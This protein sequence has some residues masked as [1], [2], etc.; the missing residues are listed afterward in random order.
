MGLHQLPAGRGGG[1]GHGHGGRGPGSQGPRQRVQVVP[2]LA[3]SLTPRSCGRCRL[4]S[5]HLL[6]S[7]RCAQK[8]R[9]PV[10]DVPGASL[11]GPCSPGQRCDI[12]RRAPRPDPT[13]HAARPSPD[14]FPVPWTL[15]LTFPGSCPRFRPAPNTACQPGW[16]L[17]GMSEKSWGRLW[18]GRTDGHSGLQHR[19]GGEAGRGAL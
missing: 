6:R 19:A 8:G 2:P 13:V 15:H 4:E 14:V 7:A 3:L 17:V 1:G 16:L 12:S 11:A 5:G 18:D 10:E 9:L